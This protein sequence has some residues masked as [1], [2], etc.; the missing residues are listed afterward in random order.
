MGGNVA[1]AA[2][3]ALRILDAKTIIFVGQDLAYSGGQHH[4]DGI[5]DGM[6]GVEDII[7]IPGID[8][9]N[10]K[11]NTMW[12]KYRDYFVRQI[13]QNPDI[14]LIDATEGGAL[15]EGSEIKTLRGTVD[16]ICTC[17]NPSEFIF[18]DIPKALDD[19]GGKKASEILDGWMA[20]LKETAVLAEN[21]WKVCNELISLIKRK[22]IDSA[23]V[24]DELQK[25]GEFRRKLYK[26]D[27]NSLLE[28]FWV[29][30]MYSVPAREL[31]VRTD[32]EAIMT[33]EQAGKYYEQ[34]V[35]DALSLGEEFDMAM[36][37]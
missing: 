20:E 31:Y 22:R 33:F 12:I 6:D 2:F 37:K 27:M 23:A 7:E 36:K 13:K 16:E 30:D 35:K 24:I 21:L 9:T 25:F 1:G 19:A 29:E 34:L 10:V 5:D 28:E 17:N 18:D 14:R 3:V 26:L 11:S 8:G 4:A 32:D 15:I